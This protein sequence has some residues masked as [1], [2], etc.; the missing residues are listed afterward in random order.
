RWV[1]YGDAAEGLIVAPYPKTELGR[2]EAAGADQLSLGFE[3]TSAPRAMRSPA[4]STFADRVASVVSQLPTGRVATYGDVARWA[5]KPAGAGA[6]R[7]G[8]NAR[9]V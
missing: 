5:G 1:A 8:L 6:A 9:Q 7:T 4:A 2:A 3:T